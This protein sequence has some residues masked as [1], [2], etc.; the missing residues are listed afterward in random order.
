MYDACRMIV[1]VSS[2]VPLTRP[3]HVT[4]SV[5]TALVEPPSVTIL[6]MLK[7]PKPLKRGPRRNEPLRSVPQELL[8]ARFLKLI[9]VTSRPS[10]TSVVLMSTRM[11]FDVCRKNGE[12]WIVPFDAFFDRPSSN[13]SVYSGLKFGLPMKTFCTSKKDGNGFSSCVPGRRMRRE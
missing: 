3:I 4:A 2:L 1:F 7:P 8:V 5:P 12:S 9:D 10:I 13:A 11:M 6:K